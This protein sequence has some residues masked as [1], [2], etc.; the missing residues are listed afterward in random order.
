MKLNQK[1]LDDVCVRC[2]LFSAG[3]FQQKCSKHFVTVRLMREARGVTLSGGFSV[4]FLIATVIGLENTVHTIT[5]QYIAQSTLWKQG[6]SRA[7]STRVQIPD[8]AQTNPEEC[9]DFLC[10]Q[11]PYRKSL[12]TLPYR[13]NGNSHNNNDNFSLIE[14]RI[15]LGRS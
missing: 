7:A 2:C 9:F 12:H 11:L 6:S 14:D 8:M 1:A 3:V 13:M 4:R 5:D 10:T 15:N